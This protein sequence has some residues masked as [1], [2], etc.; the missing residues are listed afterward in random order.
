VT[1]IRTH[2]VL[3]GFRPV[4]PRF[5]VKGYT[6]EVHGAHV[7]P[8][9]DDD[10][11]LPGRLTALLIESAAGLVLVD[12]GIGRF[13]GELDAG[14]LH[15]ELGALGVQPWDVATVVITHG[16]AD[17]VGGLTSPRGEPVFADARHLIHVAEA[18]FWASSEAAALPGDAATPARLALDALAEGGLLERIDSPTEVGPGVQAISAP[19][20]TPGHLAVVVGDDLLWAGDAIV[21]RLNVTHPAWVSAADMDGPANEATRRSLLGRAADDGLVLAG[22]HLP[23]PLRIRRDG[24]G[25]VPLDLA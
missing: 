2:V 7:R 13:A 17:H 11:R 1:S 18:A 9:L 19:G 3:D 23:A 21:A 12:A 20:H 10:G 22:S 4:S 8:F 25:F 5:V 6:D 15:E 16:H 14:H 24:E